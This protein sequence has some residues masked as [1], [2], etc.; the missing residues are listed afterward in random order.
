MPAFSLQ[1]VSD[2]QLQEVLA[3]LGGRPDPTTGA[4]LFDRYCAN[5]HGSDATGGVVGQDIAG[6]T[7][8]NVIEAAR[9]GFG[10][11]NYAVRDKFMPG[12]STQEL[13]DAELQLITDY[14]Q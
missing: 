10:R 14:L 8:N 6:E 7:L 2:Q 4:G 3:W 1:Q 9:D 5:C 13:S 12:R 11:Q